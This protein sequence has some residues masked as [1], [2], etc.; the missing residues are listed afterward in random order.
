VDSP[1]RTAAQRYGFEDHLLCKPPADWGH[2]VGTPGG[3]GE[4]FSA[5]RHAPTAA[6]KCPNCHGSGNTRFGVCAYCKGTGK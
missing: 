5:A 4:S 2:G 1:D 6:K 3:H